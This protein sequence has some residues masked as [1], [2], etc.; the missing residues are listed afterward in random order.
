ME[1][2]MY[3]YIAYVSISLVTVYISQTGVR[4]IW[5]ITYVYI[6]AKYIPY[7]GNTGPI[8]FLKHYAEYYTD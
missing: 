4:W 5:F 2:Y 7:T 8:E 6:S 3:L 1:I